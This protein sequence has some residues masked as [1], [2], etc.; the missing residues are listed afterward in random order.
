VRVELRLLDVHLLAVAQARVIGEELLLHLVR[1]RLELRLLEDRD[2][3]DLLAATV[4]RDDERR[5]HRVEQRRSGDEQEDE[6]EEPRVAEE[7]EREDE[8]DDSPHGA[9]DVEARVDR[10]ARRVGERGR[11]FVV[12]ERDHA[13]QRVRLVPHEARAAGREA[14]LHPEQ[15]HRRAQIGARELLFARCECNASQDFPQSEL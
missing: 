1:E 3:D 10:D 9:A 13:E 4:V 8:R 2:V 7:D 5:A 12:A 6:P 11:L 15:E 14:R